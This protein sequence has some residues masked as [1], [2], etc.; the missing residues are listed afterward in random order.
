M[1]IAQ[2]RRKTKKEKKSQSR[3]HRNEAN[4]YMEDRLRMEG[5]PIGERILLKSGRLKGRY[6][7][8]VAKEPGE[9]VVE[10]KKR[11]RTTLPIADCF[12]E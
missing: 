5:P 3:I 8:I 10:D 4:R 6:A 12:D 11:K 7:T 1:P 9:I 2:A